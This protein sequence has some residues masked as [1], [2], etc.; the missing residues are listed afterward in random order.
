MKRRIS[1]NK[2]WKE[3]MKFDSRNWIENS[4]NYEMCNNWGKKKI[5]KRSNKI[6]K[7][8]EKSREKKNPKTGK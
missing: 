2:I 1:E 5:I 3:R 4:E 7:M 8:K 6:M